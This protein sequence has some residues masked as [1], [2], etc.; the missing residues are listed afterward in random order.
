MKTRAKP[1]QTP[2]QR[3][4]KITSLRDRLEL[5]QGTVA[6]EDIATITAIFDGYSPR[7]AQLIAMQRPEA[8]DVRGFREWLDH[9]RCVRKG[10]HGIA[11]LAP[12]LRKR[13]EDANGEEGTEAA[14]KLATVKIAFVFDI[15][16]TDEITR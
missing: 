2:E 8:T 6:P 3:R 12:V 1:A 16:Q 7:N 10:E 15:A 5:W 4:A 11:I 13:T 9:G 14:R